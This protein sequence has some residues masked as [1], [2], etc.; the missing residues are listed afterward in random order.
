MHHNWGEALRQKIREAEE[1]RRIPPQ[2]FPRVFLL[3]DASGHMPKEALDQ[4]IEELKKLS[5]KK[6]HTR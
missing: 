4:A 1:L 2:E 5:P 6:I 3:P